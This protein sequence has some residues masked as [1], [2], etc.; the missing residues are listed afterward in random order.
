MAIK[1][2]PTVG[3][4]FIEEQILKSGI[5]NPDSKVK[6]GDTTTFVVDGKQALHRRLV[7]LREIIPGEISYD[8]AV[9]MAYKFEFLGNLLHWL[10]VNKGY[11]E[12]GYTTM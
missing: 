5:V 2:P 4:D 3:I 7:L 8:Q 9:G 1:P 10:Y 12:G 11:K 6:I